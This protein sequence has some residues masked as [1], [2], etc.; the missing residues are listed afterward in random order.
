M[1]N[2]S[3]AS[4]WVRTLRSPGAYAMCAA[5]VLLAGCGRVSALDPGS[6]QVTTYFAVIEADPSPPATHIPSPVLPG[7]FMVQ[8]RTW[9]GMC[10]G[11]PCETLLVV[12]ASGAWTYRAQGKITTGSLTRAQVIALANAVAVTQLPNATGKPDCAA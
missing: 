10:P 11:G 5:V 9:G 8:R 12:G 7:D 6:S 3:R 4:A 1:A 2:V